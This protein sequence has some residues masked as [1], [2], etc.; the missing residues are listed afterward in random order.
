MCAGAV[1]LTALVISLLPASS[2]SA[3]IKCHNGY[4]MVAGSHLATPYCQDLL[5]AHVAREYGSRVSA[6]AILYNPNVK[7]DVCRLVGWDIRVQ[8]NCKTVLPNLRG[9]H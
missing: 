7:C 2:A 5:L 4:Q 3:R 6:K 8:E 9:R 1:V